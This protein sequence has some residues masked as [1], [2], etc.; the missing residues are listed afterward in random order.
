MD[1]NDSPILDF[2]EPN[3]NSGSI[4]AGALG[5]FFNDTV[6]SLPDMEAIWELNAP[7]G[8]EINF[9]P[10]TNWSALANGGDLVGLWAE[11]NYA[12]DKTAGSSVTTNAES[13]VVYTNDHLDEVD[14]WPNDNNSSSIYLAV[15]DG[16]PNIGASWGLSSSSTFFNPGG[17]FAD[18][19]DHDGGDQGSPGFVPSSTTLLGDFNGDLKVDA[20]D[21]TVWRDGLGTLYDQDDYDDW[22]SNF[23]A[24]TGSGSAAVGAV[25]E[26]TS[27]ALVLVGLAGLAVGR[28]RV[29][30]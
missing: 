19:I 20:A 26:P 30:C 24:G 13:S 1:D 21:Y 8:V 9:I 14:P 25:P 6:V 11:G 2:D 27:I 15:H 3:V 18:V 22:K 7:D 29:G 10:V 5:V 17:I 28:R 4:A 23:G 12:T 16:N